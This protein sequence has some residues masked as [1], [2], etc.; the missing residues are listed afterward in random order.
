MRQFGLIGRSLGH[1]FSAKWFRNYFTLNGI[2]AE[3]RLFELSAIGELPELLDQ[4]PGLEGFNVT[5][6]YKKEV[7]YLCANLSEEVTEIGAANCITIRDGQ[8]YAHN[9]DTDGFR[10]MLTLLKGWDALPGA[11]ILGT[12]G[13]AAAAAFVFQKLHF[14][15]IF[16]SRNPSHPLSVSWSD[17]DASLLDQFPLIVNATPLGMWP[18]AD[19][20]PPLPCHLLTGREIIADMVYNPEETKL[21]K[22]VQEKGCMTLNG[23]DM[24]QHQ[25]LR[26]WQIWNQ[27]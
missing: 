11:M 4:Y 20:A 22:M 5:I 13:A 1:S 7:L 18:H 25:A 9:T 24:L 16:V 10:H 19:T 8:L 3:Y 26:S 17:I 14:P 12:G 2:K 6:P 27:L 23:M 21:M 15:F